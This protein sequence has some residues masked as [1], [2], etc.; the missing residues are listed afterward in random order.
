MV[1]LHG[2]GNT[3]GQGGN[4]NGA[5][6]ASSRNV[7]VVTLNYRLGVFGWFSHPALQTGDLLDD[8]GNYGTLDIIQALSW[9]RENIRAFGGN[10]KNVTVFGESAGASNVLT[11]MASPL[12][13]GLF[14]RAI[15]QSGGF[16]LH[17]MQ[18]AQAFAADGGHRASSAELVNKLILA[19]NLATT[20]EAAR[21]YQQQ[22][23][24]PR[25]REYLYSK[26]VSQLFAQL[27]AAVFGMVNLPTRFGDGHV[28]P[29]ATAEA[30]FS[31]PSRHNPVPVILGTNRDEDATFMVGDP[32]HVETW[33]GF[34]PRLKDPQAYQQLV[35]YRSLARKE[36]GVD[37]LATYMH[38]AGN[39]R[40]FAYRFDWDELTSPGGFDL[41]TAL[42]A[43]HGMEIPFV[44]NDFNTL[45]LAG[46]FPDSPEQFDLA[47][48]ITSYWTNF[49]HHG[50]P[51]SG[52]EGNLPVWHAWGTGNGH[53]LLL[54]N[55]ADPGIRMDDGIV[56]LRGIKAELAGDTTFAQAE[57]QCKAYAQSFFGDNFDQGEYVQLNP[58]CPDLDP[59][60]LSPF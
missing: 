9:V 1:W 38:R 57:T 5:S 53:T 14:H 27:P 58:V 15:S 31:D 55:P 10:P 41:A 39:P 48:A 45:G 32:A 13:K 24:T 40:V 4:Y 60:D 29:M 11:L 26:S 20:E 8:S 35:Y 3:A 16:Y 47:A 6:L 28:L 42:G 12:A 54:D 37:S 44:F 51:A 56:T 22:M 52:S 49:A 46:L 17:A 18:A 25:L 59:K 30:V 36:S 50:D 19:D 2:G 23:S 7:V 34:L 43:G 21:A 33:F